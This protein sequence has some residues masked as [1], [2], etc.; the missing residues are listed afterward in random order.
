MSNRFESDAARARREARQ[1]AGS[2]LGG[3]RS[4]GSSDGSRP[5][6]WAVDWNG[7]GRTSD[8]ETITGAIFTGPARIN[9]LIGAAPY[10]AER[11]AYRQLGFRPRVWEPTINT[12]ILGDD[13]RYS[14][15]DPRFNQGGRGGFNEGFGGRADRD[16]RNAGRGDAYGYAAAGAVGAGGGAMFANGGFL[17]PQS[18]GDNAFSYRLS[19]GGGQGITITTRGA[20]TPF[21]YEQI[22]ASLVQVASARGDDAKL[23]ALE[24]ALRQGLDP[25]AVINYNGTRYQ[26]RDFADHFIGQSFLGIG[27]ERRRD[28]QIDGLL[29]EANLR[30]QPQVPPQ[31]GGQAV[32]ISGATPQQQAFFAKYGLQSFADGFDPNNP[33][34]RATVQAFQQRYGAWPADQQRALLAQMQAEANAVGLQ[35]QWPQ[36]LTALTTPATPAV[37]SATA[38]ATP[39][40][41]TPAP[42]SAAAT[43][44]A[45]AA[46]TPSPEGSA[47][48][49]REA[50]RGAAA[51]AARLNVPTELTTRFDNTSDAAF[52][53]RGGVVL[54]DRVVDTNVRE[55]QAIMEQH[56]QLKT[57]KDEIDNQGDGRQGYRTR[58]SLMAVEK[59]LEA[60]GIIDR[61]DGL[62]DART[63]AALRDEQVQGLLTRAFNNPRFD[64]AQLNLETTREVSPD[65]LTILAEV[66]SPGTAASP[67]AQQTAGATAQAAGAVAPAAA[68][69]RPDAASTAIV[70]TPQ[71]QQALRSVGYVALSDGF[72]P[73]DTNDVAELRRANRQLATA[74]PEQRNTAAAVIRGMGLDENRILGA[75]Q[76]WNQQVQSVEAG[77]AVSPGGAGA[78]TDTP[79]TR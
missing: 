72:N 67:T 8:F 62:L 43:P 30:Y 59:V 50:D 11:D 22:G 6:P 53:G 55:A 5:N 56:V 31:A 27:D 45:T 4:S 32:G 44:A 21:Q 47:Q 63:L 51:L 38:P 36:L 65:I 19:M 2:S 48:E 12:S 68:P 37:A 41:T 71:E 16:W 58:R 75:L 46:A 35:S 40:A 10:A 28:R 73:N 61:A 54:N 39:A 15:F 3:G 78:T 70:L 20:L 25:E 79:R 77:A 17:P 29:T 52:T 64:R 76:Q 23:Q 42:A 74:T 7:N 33:T 14:R 60:A 24:S 18:P 69:A 34:D 13:P 66:G 49:S 1:A 9:T 57:D 26:L